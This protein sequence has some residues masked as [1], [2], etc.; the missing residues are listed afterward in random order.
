M[1]LRK[2]FE[3]KS[4]WTAPAPGSKPAPGL[5]TSTFKGFSKVRPSSSVPTQHR[6]D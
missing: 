6:E 4:E 3:R 5:Q 1:D 2:T